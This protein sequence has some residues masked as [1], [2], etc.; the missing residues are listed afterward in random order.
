MDSMYAMVGDACWRC[1]YSRGARG[2]RVLDF[3]HVDPMEKSFSLDSRHIINLAKSRVVAE[4]RKCV[5]L[6]ANC[7]REAPAGLIPREEILRLHR[8]RWSAIR[9]NMEG[10]IGDG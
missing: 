8:E 3:H 2:R 7:H 5:L 6:C 1:G 10:T 4:L 9:E